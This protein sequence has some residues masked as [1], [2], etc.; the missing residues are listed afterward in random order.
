MFNPIRCLFLNQLLP[1][2]SQIMVQAVVDKL[3]ILA[4]VQLVHPMTNKIDFQF[5]RYK[6]KQIFVSNIIQRM[7]KVYGSIIFFYWNWIF[8][9][10]S[11]LLSYSFYINE[12]YLNICS[13]VQFYYMS[14]LYDFPP[15]FHAINYNITKLCRQT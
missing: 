8:Y 3:I 13:F 15:H 11:K 10:F 5:V 14:T 1:N 6:L 12:K 4:V 2:K 7:T 9:I